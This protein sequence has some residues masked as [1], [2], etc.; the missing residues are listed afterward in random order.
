M[1]IGHKIWGDKGQDPPAPPG[2]GAWQ[3]RRTSTTSMDSTQSVK[4]EIRPVSFATGLPWQVAAQKRDLQLLTAAK[5]GFLGEVADNEG[6]FSFNSAIHDTGQASLDAYP[7]GLGWARGAEE[8]IS[9]VEALRLGADV[10]AADNNGNTALHYACEEG[11]T[12]MAEFLLKC[13]DINDAATSMMDWTP[14]HCAASKGRIDIVRA[15]LRTEC[16]INALAR[17]RNTALHLAA[18]GGHLETLDTLLSNGADPLKQNMDGQTPSDLASLFKNGPYQIIVE[19]LHMSPK[20]PGRTRKFSPDEHAL[21]IT[22]LEGQDI[23]VRT[24]QQDCKCRNERSEE[25]V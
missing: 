7:V 23:A 5:K 8:E 14:L 1:E 16:H 12:E 19:R 3:D 4:Q 20:P 10:N 9:V 6:S 15:L 18:M 22:L 24:P 21:Q 2:T 17:D 13:V 11:Y 25:I